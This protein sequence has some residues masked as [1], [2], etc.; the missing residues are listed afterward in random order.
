MRRIPLAVLI[1]ALFA[2]AALAGGP[3]HDGAHHRGD[4]SKV[5][6]SIQIGDG[7]RAGDVESVNGSITIG[8]DAVVEN[9]ETVNGSVRIGANGQAESLET[10]NGSITVGAKTVVQ[11]GIET[12]NGAITLGDDAA[13][14]DKIETVNGRIELGARAQAGAGIELVNGDVELKRDARV[15]G[16]IV[17]RKPHNPGWFSRQSKTPRV[18]LGPNAVVD[19]DL[20]FEREVELH[21]HSSAKVTGKQHGPLAGG[22][23]HTFS[24]DTPNG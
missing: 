18:I 22:K 5:N 16:D 24:G 23:V 20:V 3:E 2:T 6:R 19:G 15:T 12:V 8:D 13:S 21:M 4:I 9:A 11:E 7:E 17:V 1:S 10:V 14:L